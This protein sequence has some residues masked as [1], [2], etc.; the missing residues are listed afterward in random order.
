MIFHKSGIMMGGVLLPLVEYSFVNGGDD[1]RSDALQYFQR[2]YSNISNFNE[3]FKTNLNY[4][5]E[6]PGVFDEIPNEGLFLNPHF[7]SEYFNSI[8]GDYDF[9]LQSWDKSH[10][11]DIAIIS[12][13]IFD[14]YI[15][16]KNQYYPLNLDIILSLG[17]HESEALKDISPEDLWNFR[18]FRSVKERFIDEKIDFS[19]SGSDILFEDLKKYKFLLIS[20]DFLASDDLIFRLKKYCELGGNLISIHHSPSFSERFSSD[21]C[22]SSH[23]KMTLNKSASFELFKVGNGSHLRFYPPENADVLNLKPDLNITEVLKSIFETELIVSKDL[24]S[25]ESKVL[26]ALKEEFGRLAEINT[27]V[28]SNKKGFFKS[29]KGTSKISI[30]LD[31]LKLKFVEIF[32]NS[33]TQES[34]THMD[35]STAFEN[36]L[37]DK[38]ISWL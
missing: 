15:R 3:K 36:L 16:T 32:K 33:K 11:S 20:S 13:N 37:N 5:E 24:V 6:L 9:S 34:F 17:S 28:F 23:L 31:R 19:Y 14:S 2:S 38:V 21:L 29:S 1:G 26:H 22:N 7:I 18:A 30:D 27:V 25:K 35:L 12:N 4:F 8:G 10:S